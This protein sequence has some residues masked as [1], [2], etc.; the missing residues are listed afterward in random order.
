MKGKWPTVEIGKAFETSAGGT[1][2]RSNKQY[3]E[4]GAIPWLMSGEVGQREIKSCANFITETG[5]ASCSARLLPI[6]TV[7]V[8]MYG[9]TAGQVG[10]LKFEACTNQAVC[11]LHPNSRFEPSFVYYAL[12]AQQRELIASAVG[13]A[14]PNLSQIKI[15]KVRIPEPPLPEQRRIVGILDEAFAGLATAEANAARNLQNAREIFDSHLHAVF[16]QRGAARPPVPLRQC[17]EDIATGLFGSLLHK[18]DYEAGG[19]PLVNPINIEG[20]AIVPDDRK[21]VGRETAERLSRYVLK[22]N[23]IVIGRRGEIG[24]CAVITSIEAGWICGTGCF[25]IRPTPDTNP[26]YLAHLLRSK[27]Y[28]EQLEAVSKRAT[29]PSISNED[30]ANLDVQIPPLPQQKM[31]LRL[32]NLVSA[33][34]QRLATLQQRKISA[35]GELKKSLLHQAFAGGL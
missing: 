26:H 34:T 1:P 6:D 14:Q 35:L 15:R 17:V 22:E 3:F 24:R 20:E 27:P 33:K 8:A 16:S 2:S 29:M 19:I 10:V 9:A 7:L 18:S 31:V 25:V 32:L 30:L 13:N 28:R 11:G 12:L 5:L 4:G 21:A 23:D